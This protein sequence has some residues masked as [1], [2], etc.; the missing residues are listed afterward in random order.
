LN[1]ELLNTV[2]AT[3]LWSHLTTPESLNDIKTSVSLN[4]ESLVT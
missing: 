3:L 4:T 1:T 2:T